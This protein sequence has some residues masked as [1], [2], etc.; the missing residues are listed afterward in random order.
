MPDLGNAMQRCRRCH[1]WSGNAF[2]HRRASWAEQRRARTGCEDTLVAVR[3]HG[4]TTEAMLRR[5]ISWAAELKRVANPLSL[6]TPRFWFLLDATYV[7]QGKV[8]E[9]VRKLADEAGLG[10][11][12]LEVF[13]YTEADMIRQYPAL[14]GIRSSLPETQDV[15]DSFRLPG[16]KSLAWCFHVEAILLWWLH[17]CSRSPQPSFAWII[18]D[19]AG[20]SGSFLHFLRAYSADTSD[21]LAHAFRHVEPRWVWR[22][23]ASPAFLESAGSQRLR[24]AEHV[25]RF[26]AG[27]LHCLSA[28][29]KKGVSAWSEMSVPTLCRAASLSLGLL[30][31]EHVGAVFTFNGKVPEDQWSTI[32]AA[33]KTKDRWWHALKW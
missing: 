15:L 3:V 14:V 19:D 13:R 22:D 7:E 17:V 23:A 31:H 2:R 27:L 26:S 25:Q 8:E 6:A 29:A 12:A 21:L 20:L 10:A 30:R 11:R 32:C 16:P 1:S 24:C 5:H 18:E 28:F 33:G 4:G 9:L